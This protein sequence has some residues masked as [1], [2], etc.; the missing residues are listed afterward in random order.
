MSPAN[1]GASWPSTRASEMPTPRRSVD[2]AGRREHLATATW[3][4]AATGGYVKVDTVVRQIVVDTTWARSWG[5][6]RM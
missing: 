4:S 2:H 5:M 1:V 6:R 3:V